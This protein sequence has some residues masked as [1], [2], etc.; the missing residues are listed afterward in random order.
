G[1]EASFLAK[2]Q[3]ATTMAGYFADFKLLM[4][5]A[6]AFKKPVFVLLEPDGYGF[7]QQQAN[8]NPQT[9]AAVATTSLPELAGLPDTVAGW[10]LAFLAIRK[11][12]GA[13]NAVLGMHISE[14]ASGKDLSCCSVTDPLEPE[15]TKVG[16]F[17]APLGLAANTTGHTYDVLVG[18]PLDRD[19]DY[20][21]VVRSDPNRWWDASDTAPITSR[22][23]NR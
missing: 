17:L 2:A 18:D 15:V 22:S 7:L 20:Y 1:S 16:D 19:S 6:K 23:F 5:R 10:G 4:E 11:S 8:S 12:V 14:W 13:S 21:R 9:T 3:N